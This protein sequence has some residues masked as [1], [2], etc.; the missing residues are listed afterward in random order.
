MSVASP[1]T[2]AW[3][4]GRLTLP[5]RSRLNGGVLRLEGAGIDFLAQEK[6]GAGLVSLGVFVPGMREHEDESTARV[7]GWLVRSAV[8]APAASTPQRLS[9]AAGSLSRTH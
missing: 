6:R 8:P 7:S 4:D 1:G 9:P 5:R 2:G 3:T